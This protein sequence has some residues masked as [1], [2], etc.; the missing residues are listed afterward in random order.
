MIFV[1]VHTV[2]KDILSFCFKYFIYSEIYIYI[3]IYITIISTYDH[4]N[5]RAILYKEPKDANLAVMFISNCKI[6]LHVSDAF[7]VHHQEY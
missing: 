6:T 3:Y 4:N 7:C 5:I 2:R 1:F